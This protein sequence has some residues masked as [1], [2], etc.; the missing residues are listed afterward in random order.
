MPH[1]APALPRDGAEGA[2]TEGAGAAAERHRDDAGYGRLPPTAPALE[3]QRVPASRCDRRVFEIS[4]PPP[5]MSMSR[6]SKGP[7]TKRSSQGDGSD[8]NPKRLRRESRSSAYVS[9]V[10]L[11]S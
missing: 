11:G 7:G 2:G 8:A 4:A 6:K 1:G 10:D 3:Q 9:R 5:G